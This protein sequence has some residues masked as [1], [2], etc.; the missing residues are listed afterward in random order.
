MNYTMPGRRGAPS[1]DILETASE[2]N[3]S[4]SD[5]GGATPRHNPGPNLQMPDF[6]PSATGP[7]ILAAVENMMLKYVT[8]GDGRISPVSR[9]LQNVANK[10]GQFDGNE[11]TDYRRAYEA[12][13]DYLKISNYD[14]MHHFYLVSSP[15]LRPAIKNILESMIKVT[16][17]DSFAD[18][19]R[20]EFYANDSE[21]V[22][23]QSFLKWVH[24]KNKGLTLSNLLREF[25]RQYSHLTPAE[26]SVINP[27]RVT[28]FLTAC[29]EQMA[30]ELDDR[31]SSEKQRLDSFVNG[32]HLRLVDGFSTDLV[33]GG[34]SETSSRARTQICTESV[35]L[36]P[37]Y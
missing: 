3:M 24:A 13:M 32:V 4:D 9:A 19:L 27:E 10:H 1:V 16:D 37:R 8:K 17:W 29:D 33:G 12:E 6:P 20:Q 7:E 23:R 5:E 21:R 35:D 2:I 22:T 18:K 14:R 26:R 36:Q 25:E 28:L 11:I 15:D 30:S 34:L 31:N